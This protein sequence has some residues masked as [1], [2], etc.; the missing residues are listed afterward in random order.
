[1]DEDPAH[2]PSDRAAAF[3]LSTRLKGEGRLPAGLIHR[4]TPREADPAPD[5]ARSEIDPSALIDRYREI[6][7]GYAIA[8]DGAASGG[9]PVAGGQGTVRG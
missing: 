1:M 2:D 4:A 3:A 5:P 6:M 8:A 9:A 7:E